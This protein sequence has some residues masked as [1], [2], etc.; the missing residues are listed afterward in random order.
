[1]T[2]IHKTADDWRV[3]PNLVD[4]ERTRATFDWLTAPNPCIGMGPGECNI[5]YTATGTPTGR[6]DHTPH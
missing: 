5:A 1:M 2:V 3:A 6:I 4:Y